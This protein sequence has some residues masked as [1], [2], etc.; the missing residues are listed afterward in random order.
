MSNKLY[1]L[2]MRYM[3]A[4]GLIVFAFD[5]DDADTKAA[6][7]AAVDEA[8][9]PVLQKNK[10][11]LGEVKKAKRGAEI[12]PAEHERLENELEQTRNQLTDAQKA[13]K[14]AAKQAEDATK[15]LQGEQSF[16]QSLLVDNGLNA[17]LL[18]AGVKNPAHLKAAAAYLKSSN[19]I[20]IKVDADGNR[21]AVVGDKA[22]ADFAKGWS[23]SDEGKHFVA[24][25]VNGGGGAG[26]GG[27]GGGGGDKKAKEMSSGEK[28]AFIKENGF[29]KWNE[30]VATDYAAPAKQS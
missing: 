4:T 6:L 12:D 14:V 29:D 2:L 25:P 17:A 18:E 20:E 19:K 1:A 26:G 10:E 7:K 3:H 13:A 9:A 8:L 11:L 16:T 24:A 5:P 22:L 15:Q 27:N 21:S 23:A 30:K 28:A